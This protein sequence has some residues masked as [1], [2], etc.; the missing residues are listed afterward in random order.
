MDIFGNLKAII[1]ARVIVH[2][3]FFEIDGEGFFSKRLVWAYI[4][5]CQQKGSN[6]NRIHFN[7]FV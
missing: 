5:F 6:R 1:A 4:C 3:S 2:D 7:D